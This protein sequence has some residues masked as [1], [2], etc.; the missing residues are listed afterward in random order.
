MHMS[1][2]EKLKHIAFRPFDRGDRSADGERR[3]ENTDAGAGMINPN[4]LAQGPA[5][6]PPDYVKTDDGRPRH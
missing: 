1:I 5:Q 3:V 6:F 4:P 2:L